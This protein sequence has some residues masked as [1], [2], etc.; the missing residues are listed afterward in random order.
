MEQT[1]YNERPSNEIDQLLAGL[2]TAELRPL[3]AVTPDGLNSKAIDDKAVFCNEEHIGTVSKHYKL[4]QHKDAFQPIVDGIR[5]SGYTDFRFSAWATNK[6]AS[7][8]ITLGEAIDTVRYGFKATSGYDGNHAISFGFKTERVKRN[9]VVVE[10]EH[11][12]V[13]GMRQV[14]SNG[15]VVKVPIKSTKYLTIETR[16]R[17]STI[18]TEYRKLSHIGDMS[19]KLEQIQYLVEAFL[20]LKNPLEAMIRDA[21]NK[22]LDKEQARQFIETYIGTRLA[23]RLME[24]YAFEQQTLWGLYNAATNVAS[25]DNDLKASTKES[26]LD[27][28]ATML[29]EELLAEAA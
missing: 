9:D 14:C 29:T 7:L 26:L 13:W 8:G 27:K 22:P 20:L 2:P 12:Q 5:Q 3:V 21:Q 16:E 11:I 25:H 4:V 10:R 24:Q 15:M 1:T 19:V 18:M 28:S 17:V 23:D 6:Q